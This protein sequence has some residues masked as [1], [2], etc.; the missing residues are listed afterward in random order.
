MINGLDLV[1]CVDGNEKVIMLTIDC[2]C[3]LSV[4]HCVEVVDNSV[5]AKHYTNDFLF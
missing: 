5:N 3:F 1:V 4:L 2:I